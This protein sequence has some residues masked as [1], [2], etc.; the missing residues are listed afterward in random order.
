MPIQFKQ[1][2]Q[3]TLF[4][5]SSSQRK[6][7]RKADKVRESSA[8]ALK[9]VGWYY[10][11]YNV[12]LMIPLECNTSLMI[13]VHWDVIYDC[14]PLPFDISR[15]S[16]FEDYDMPRY[17]AVMS[18]SLSLPLSLSPTAIDVPRFDPPHPAA[19]AVLRSSLLQPSKFPPT[20][21]IR[22]NYPQKQT[23]KATRVVSAPP[24]GLERWWRWRFNNGV[25]NWTRPKG[26]LSLAPVDDP[27]GTPNP[28]VTPYDSIGRK[29]SRSQR[30]SLEWHVACGRPV[31]RKWGGR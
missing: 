28:A 19:A 25:C 9:P 29:V 21:E 10:Y 18:E 3:E 14:A 23:E 27:P 30:R 2:K 24:M 20:L 5:Q 12:H 7:K 31:G 26:L 13:R 16:A 15:E 8:A 22:R 1:I 11:Y 4:L 17:V 6:K